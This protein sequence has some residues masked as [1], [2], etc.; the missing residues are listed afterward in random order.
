MKDFRPIAISEIHPDPEQPRKFFDRASLDELT[1]SVKKDG[2]LEPIMIRPNGEGYIIVYGERRFKAAAAAGLKEIPAQIRDLTPEEAFEFQITENL[3]RKDVHPMEE[4]NSYER[5]QKKDPIKNTVKELATRFA[6]SEVYIL[7]RLTFNKLTPE[8]QKDFYKGDFTVSHA[9]MFSRLPAVDQN[10]LR[11]SNRINNDGHYGTASDL[12]EYI[13]RNIVRSLDKAPFDKEDETLNPGAGPCSKCP[14]RSGCNKLLFFEVKEDDRC[15]DK[16]CFATKTAT[17]FNRNLL[18][19]IETKPET[20]FLHDHYEKM[21]PEL[22]KLLQEHKIKPLKSGDDYSTHSWSGSNFKIKGKGFH[23]TGYQAGKFETIYLKGKSKEVDTKTGKVKEPPAADLIKGI[24]ERQKRSKELDEEKVW[25]LLRSEFKGEKYSGNDADFT[26]DERR[27]ISKAMA[28]KLGFQEAPAFRKF[29]KIDERQKNWPD[30]SSA[31]LRQMIRFFLF[32]TLPPATLYSGHNIDSL[33]SL[34]IAK[35]YFPDVL[36]KLQ[37]AQDDIAAKRI[38]RAGVRIA[39]LKKPAIEKHD[40]AI[41]KKEVKL[42]TSKDK[43]VKIPKPQKAQLIDAKGN[44]K[45]LPTKKVKKPNK[46]SK[47]K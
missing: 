16:S 33:L 46:S 35:Q 18:D 15:F 2:V 45:P 20:H 31:M 10:E 37:K 9:V 40:R 30:V 25:A 23:L 17:S 42:A 26:P 39:A 11:K 44:K 21:P 24:Q 5:L 32:A 12:Q 34:N 43:K 14:K 38:E 19:I 4:A 28:N 13:Q 47:K 29:F 3:H 7:Q 6:K 22:N 41:E 27:A 8:L 36:N 1:L